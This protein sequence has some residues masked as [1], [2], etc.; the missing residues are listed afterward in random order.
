MTRKRVDP[1]IIDVVKTNPV[2]RN[3]MPA[4]GCCP[5]CQLG[6]AL[7]VAGRVEPWGAI[8]ELVAARALPQLA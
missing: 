7:F 3:P 2:V 5:E 4:M 6:R 1:F 8:I